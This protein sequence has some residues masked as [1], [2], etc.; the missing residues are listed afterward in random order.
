MKPGCGGFIS[1]NAEA[2]A[3]SACRPRCWSMFRRAAAV[4][5]DTAAS[6]V[7]ARRDD[8]P[9]ATAMVYESDGVASLQWVGTVP[10]E[11]ATGLGALVT[12]L[13]TTTWRSQVARRPVRCRRPRWVRPCTTAWATRRC[14]TTRST[15]AGPSRQRADFRTRAGRGWPAASPVGC[16][17]SRPVRRHQQGGLRIAGCS[18]LPGRGAPGDRRCPKCG[19]AIRPLVLQRST[20]RPNPRR[21][22]KSQQRLDALTRKTG[23][24]RRDPEFPTS[25]SGCPGTASGP[26]RP[27]GSASTAGCSLRC[28]TASC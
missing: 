24:R 6:I 10:A 27:M 9:V 26:S 8:T 3:T 16:S 12:V 13:A 18:R 14:I 17:W 2:Y 22:K 23:F 5:A 21:V 28:S 1:V 19:A 15:C 7:V 25:R 20:P 4:L 11:R